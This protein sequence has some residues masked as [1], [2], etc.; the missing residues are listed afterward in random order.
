MRNPLP[1]RYIYKHRDVWSPQNLVL[2]GPSS[3]IKT[4]GITFDENLLL[5]R[6]EVLELTEEHEKMYAN[7]LANDR[8]VNEIQLSQKAKLLHH[9]VNVSKI[10]EE[11]AIG[12]KDKEKIVKRN[13]ELIHFLL[14]LPASSPKV[15]GRH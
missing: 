13:N 3:V 1:N 11:I 12:D 6:I 14:T 15:K 8:P 9:L 10:F 4:K 2:S 7:Q 5:E